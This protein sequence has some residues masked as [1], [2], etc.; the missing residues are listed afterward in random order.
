MSGAGWKR[1][2]YLPHLLN[3]A[4][5]AALLALFALTLRAY[6]LPRP[7]L[8]VK[9]GVLGLLAAALLAAVLLGGERLNAAA[10]LIAMGLLAFGQWR[11]QPRYLAD[12]PAGATR[13]PAPYVMFA[14]L[15]GEQDHNELGYR[16]ELPPPRKEPG[17]F[18]VLVIGGSAVYGKGPRHLTIPRQ[19]WALA[20]LSG[21]RQVRVFNWGVV[22]QVSGQE[23]ATL[24]LRAGR[25]A[26]DLVVLYS[27]GNDV[28][29]SYTADPRP[30][31]PFNFVVQQR[32]VDVFQE[33]DVPALLAGALLQ[34]NLARRFSGVELQ[35]AVARL[36]ALRRQVG[37][38][39]PRWEEEVAQAYL[40]HVETACRVGGG[41][42][43]RVAAVLQPLVYQTPQADAYRGM[44]PE[45]RQYAER[46][47]DRM[48]R[49][50]AE[51]AARQPADR[52][53]FADL[54]QACAQG[55]C[56]FQDFIHPTPET[57]API[58]EALLH[59]LEGAGLLPPPTEKPAGP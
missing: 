29:A 1:L 38:L 31:Y 34:V 44:P 5:A 49:G 17:E 11:Y 21:R 35:D 43:F 16:G 40:D 26:P 36:P 27:G 48:R 7:V 10:A 3:A 56:T 57:R 15:P 4:A 14:G 59:R 23:L 58:A 37:Y 22:S 6:S 8:A 51:L 13:Y 28:Y 45:F 12:Y 46:Q 47:Y 55:Q 42:G 39:T 52:C 54:S 2:R 19:L 50:L 30:G 25:Y 20:R 9:A 24:A 18:R 41:L 33:G 53:L 32:A